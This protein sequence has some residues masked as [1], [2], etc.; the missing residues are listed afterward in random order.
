MSR[1]H[2]MSAKRNSE[3]LV[4]NIRGQA[5]LA[6]V[7][8]ITHELLYSIH[9]A[10]PDFQKDSEPVLGAVKHDRIE[11]PAEEVAVVAGFRNEFEET[12]KTTLKKTAPGT[13]YGTPPDEDI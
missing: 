5:S 11:Q 2:S 6:L 3:W 10:L 8:Q 4:K 12:M 9:Q 13:R 1:N 7:R